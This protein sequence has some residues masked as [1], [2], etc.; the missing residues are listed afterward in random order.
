MVAGVAVMLVVIAA[1]AGAVAAISS[2]TDDDS[3]D[4]E[5]LSQ[6]VNI[7]MCVKNFHSLVLDFR[8]G[9]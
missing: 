1:L 7:A 4:T 2:K 3:Y 6:K 9:Q 8:C 5:A